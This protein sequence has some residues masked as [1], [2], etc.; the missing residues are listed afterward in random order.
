M[1]GA[2][3][4]HADALFVHANRHATTP[5]QPTPHTRMHTHLHLHTTANTARSPLAHRQAPSTPS[6]RATRAASR[7]WTRPSWR[8]RARGGRSLR[9]QTCE[10]ERACVG[11][12]SRPELGTGVGSSC[13]PLHCT[14]GLACVPGRVQQQYN[15][16]RQLKKA[17]QVAAGRAALALAPPCVRGHLMLMMCRLRWPTHPL[18]PTRSPPFPHKVRRAGAPEEAVPCGRR[19]GR[20]EGPGG[21][22]AGQAE[23]GLQPGA[24][25]D[26]KC[27]RAG[28]GG[29]G[30][31]SVQRGGVVRV[32]VRV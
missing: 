32:A 7:S 23:G 2:H 6:A 22:G 29:G 17:R 16:P 3:L 19:R 14:A 13:P 24:Q 18:T 21:G 5:P 28:G 11:M 10:D 31:R 4:A 20:Q 30:R 1:P 15:H 8:R 25:R 12:F 26:G 9:T 27:G